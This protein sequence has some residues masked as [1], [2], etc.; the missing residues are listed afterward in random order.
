M[1]MAHAVSLIAEGVFEKYPRLR[2]L[3]DEVDQFWAVGLMW[4]MDADWKS[5]R[6]QTP[7]VKRLPSAYVR[8]HIRLG[9]QPL[10]E[11]ETDAQFFCMLDAL[12]AE[13]TL[14]Y[15]SDWP[16]WDWDDP[17]TTFPKLPE[18]LHRRVFAENAREMFG[19]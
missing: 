6:D 18:R 11:P 8:E 1:G 7:W 3:F 19:L 13:E 5:L 12:H 17:A 2:V 16:H 10:L 9:S 15:A 4:H 14:V